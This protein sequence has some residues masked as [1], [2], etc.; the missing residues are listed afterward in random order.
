MAKKSKKAKLPVES[1]VAPAMD[2]ARER[3]YQIEDRL[4]TL[5][6]AAEISGDKSLMKDIKALANQTVASV[7][8]LSK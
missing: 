2:R 6:R 1:C 7:A 4:R 5:Q 8:K 3:Q